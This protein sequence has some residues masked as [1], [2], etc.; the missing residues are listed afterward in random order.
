MSQLPVLYSFRR[1]P[2]AIRARMALQAGQRQVEL[3]E[4]LLKAKPQQLLD[5]SVKATV[6]VLQLENGSV[7]DESLDI[8]HWALSTSRGSS[9][10]CE[11]NWQQH[12][13]IQHNDGEF[14]QHLDHYKYADRFPEASEA[15]YRIRALPN[16]QRLNS[17]LSEKSYLSG[18]SVGVLD[19]AIFPFIRQF[20]AVDR[21]WFF[22]NEL[23]C[24]QNW[25]N[26][27][28]EDDL[29]VSVMRKYKPWSSGDVPKVFPV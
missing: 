19:V 20:A 28:L 27:F 23:V 5:L 1:C 24:L 14:K 3:R 21:D 10:V 15:D 13:L 12:E 7:L 2:Y 9:L 4:V 6:P 25:L 16:L 11:N 26:V 22:S 18:S 29:F 17:I 8:M